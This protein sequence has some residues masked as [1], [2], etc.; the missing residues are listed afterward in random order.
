AG[1]AGGGRRGFVE[2]QR[3]WD[4]ALAEGLMAAARA[5][6][7]S[8]VIGIMGSGHL[9]HGH[10]V[11]HQLAAL[12]AGHVSVLLPWDASRDC[13]ALA[14]DLADAVFGI[15]PS[16]EEPESRPRLGVALAPAEQGVGVSEVT[17]GSVAAAAGFRRGDVVIEAAGAAVASPDDLHAVV[18][19]QAPGTWLPLVVRRGGRTLRLVAHFERPS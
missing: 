15:A 19:V 16:A 8:L 10:G 4:R 18:D 1:G 9:E 3:T 11:P 6:P 7:G 2:A 5:H 14:P 17:A 13:A 12:G